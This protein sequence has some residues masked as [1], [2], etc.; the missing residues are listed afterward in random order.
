M[1]FDSPGALAVGTAL[2]ADLCP[3]GEESV[4]ARGKKAGE[5]EPHAPD[6]STPIKRGVRTPD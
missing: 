4:M 3:Q 1:A 2:L 6:S 5:F